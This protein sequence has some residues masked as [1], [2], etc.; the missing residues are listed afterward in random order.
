MGPAGTGFVSAAGRRLKTVRIGSW[1]DGP[2]LVFLHEGLGSITQWKDFPAALAAASGLPAL[3][4]DR[5]GHGG[6]DP[7]DGP[8]P[9][10]FLT[11]EAVA[12]LPELLAAT[13]IARPVLIGHSDGGTIALIHASAFP[14]RPAAC[15]T[16]AA[17]VFAEPKMGQGVDALMTRWRTDA[18]FRERLAR[19]HG[20]RTEAMFRGFAETWMRPANRAFDIREA[21]GAVTS[22][23]LAI[24]GEDDDHGTRRQVEEIL[25]RVR[26]PAEGFM[27]PSCGHA[28]HLEQAANVLERTAAFLRRVGAAPDDPSARRAS[29]PSRHRRAMG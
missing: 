4:Y 19:H 28:P 24:Q 13:G 20:D 9:D 18:A 12:A 5:Y 29:Q 17:H 3:L 2:V 26:G 23:V 11:R 21:L 6:S 22:P 15:V 1:S 25:A 10:D 27:I 16:E 14:D 7:L 8:R